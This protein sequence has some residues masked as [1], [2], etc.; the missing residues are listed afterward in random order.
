MLTERL[1]LYGIPIRTVASIEE[2]PRT[3]HVRYH[4]PR[5]ALEA[6]EKFGGRLWK[7]EGKPGYWY[8]RGAPA[9][10]LFSGFGG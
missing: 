5:H 3:V 1:L 9:A 7:V 4:D 6:I 8:E 2:L 10:T